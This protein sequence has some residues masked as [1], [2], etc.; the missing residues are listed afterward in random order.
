MASSDNDTD[1]DIDFSARY[2]IAGYGG[3]AFYLTG[4]KKIK[5]EDYEWSGIET[6][7]KQFVEAIMV[8]DDRLH[9]VDVDDLTVLD[10]ESYCGE[11]GQ[12]GCTA[13]GR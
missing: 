4:Y 2:S 8:G 10:P 13:D 9:Y 3:I 7:D 12:I 5:D 1:C 6:E 11:C